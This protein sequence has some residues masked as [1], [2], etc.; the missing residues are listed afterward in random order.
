MTLRRMPPRRSNRGA[1]YSQ[2]HIGWVLFLT[3]KLTKYLAR[4]MVLFFPKRKKSTNPVNLR[5]CDQYNEW[6]I[7]VKIWI[8]VHFYFQEVNHE[9]S[10]WFFK[11]NSLW[12]LYRYAAHQSLPIKLNMEPTNGPLEKELMNSHSFQIPCLTSLQLCHN[13]IITAAWAMREKAPT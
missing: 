2:L 9:V 5:G 8:I 12:K 4:H 11:A 10:K 3:K 13:S 7:S 1:G 6:I